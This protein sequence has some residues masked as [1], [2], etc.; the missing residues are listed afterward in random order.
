MVYGIQAAKDVKL[1]NI[2]RTLKEDQRLLKTE[3]RL[4]RNLDDVDFTEGINDEICLLGASK[5]TEEMVIASDP[6]DLQKSMPRRWSFW[7]GCEMGVR[8][9]WGGGIHYARR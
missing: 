4:S 6:G 7:A 8:V 3:D 5:V 1:S 2:A 9:R